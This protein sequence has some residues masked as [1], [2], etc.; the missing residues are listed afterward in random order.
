[1]INERKNQYEYDRTGNLIKKTEIDDDGSTKT[2]TYSYDFENRLVKVVKQE[3]GESKTISFK[4][5]SFGR[6]IEKKIEGIEAGIA[7]TKTYNYVYDNEDIIVEYLSKAEGGKNKTE[8]TKY[9]HGPGIDEPLII[10][11]KGE[12]YYY[13]ADGI[14]SISTLTDVR[15]K[16]VE[17]YTY[18]SFGDLKHQGDKVKNTYTFTGREWDEEIGLY[19][20]RARYYDAEVGRFTSFDPILRGINHIDGT[21][22]KQSIKKFSLNKPIKLHPFIYADDN[23]INF[24]DPKG[25]SKTKTETTKYLHGP[26]I[27][28][29]MAVERKGESYYY[30]A[31]GLGSITALTDARQ[32]AVE[33]Y[34]YTSF[35]EIKE[36]GDKVKNI[37]AF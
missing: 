4:Y 3:D 12:A 16:V 36:H 21:S 25:L 20:Y 8:I 15:Q 14:G 17:G 27:D 18:T 9:L 5:D 26:G 31:N 23:P 19:Y 7:E 37:Y 33:S 1:M 28:E 30:H 2:W 11:R 29:P 6:R 13:H 35:G 22:C 24:V 32:K 34:D 10:E